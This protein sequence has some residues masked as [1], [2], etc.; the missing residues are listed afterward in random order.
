[1]EERET[2]IIALRGETL[3]E[4]NEDSSAAE[5]FQNQTLRPILKMQNALLL[6]AFKPIFAQY[7]NEFYTLNVRKREV[8]INNI[9][10]KEAKFI[11]FLKGM[12]VGMFSIAEYQIYTENLNDL[13]KR[14][15]SMLQE[16]I[17]S[18]V[19]RFENQ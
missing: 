7:K 6:A 1:M 10:Q 16:R 17:R 19:E 14:L 9:F 13:N 4:V 5:A 2:M 11:H 18:Q 3:G 8:Y 12:I 15:T